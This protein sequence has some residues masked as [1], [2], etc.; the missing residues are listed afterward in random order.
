[1]EAQSSLCS[2]PI[3]AGNVT[4]SAVPFFRTDA[5]RGEIVAANQITGCV[6]DGCNIEFAP[7]PPNK[8]VVQGRR[9]KGDPILI[10]PERGVEPSVEFTRYFLNLAN[11]NIPGQQTV[12]S[13]IDSAQTYRRRRWEIRHL[14]PSVDSCIRSASRNRPDGLIQQPTQALLELS[15]DCTL[16]GLDLP[17]FVCRAVV[18]QLQLY[19]SLP[20]ASLRFDRHSTTAQRI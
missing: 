16:I 15:L 10:G 2:I 20:R 14:T 6:L 17:A 1:M 18:F 7:D 8:S 11:R 5:E 3:T 9:R 13:G 4:N 12:Q 19:V